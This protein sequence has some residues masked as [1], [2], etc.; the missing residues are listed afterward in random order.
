MVL[1][2]FTCEKEKWD[3]FENYGSYCF[4][5]KTSGNFKTDVLRKTC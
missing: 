4:M 1:T 5:T 3:I 2:Y